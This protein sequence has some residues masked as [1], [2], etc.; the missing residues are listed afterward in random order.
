MRIGLIPNPDKDIGLQ[1]TIE[2]ASQISALGGISVLDRKYSDYLPDGRQNI[3]F[4]D[5]GNVDI[6]ICLG[7]DGTFLTAI[8][9]TFKLHTP[10]IG[11]NMGSVGFL[12]EISP[13][14]IEASIRQLFAGEY[15]T[16]KRMMLETVCR[17]SNGK[18]KGRSVSLNDLVI[19]R[20]GISRI[21]NLDLYIDGFLV[22]KLPG[23]GVIVSTP[24]GSTAYSLSAGG[25]IIQPDLEM[26]LI[27]PLNPHTLHNRCYIAGSGSRIEIVVKD[28]PFNP[29]LTSDGIH[30]CML[31][32]S[33]RITVSK[34]KGHMHLIRLNPVNFYESLTTKIYSRGN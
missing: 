24:T 31:E 16:E 5:Y 30:V 33:D 25:P 6:L 1:R 15:T 11:V 26:L 18:I 32:Q 3:V 8:H 20:G 27:T 10:I 22:E 29:L 9:D 13:D 23:D 19:S 28:Y 17:S 21:L 2:M 12:A 34:A 7:G 4:S 14:R